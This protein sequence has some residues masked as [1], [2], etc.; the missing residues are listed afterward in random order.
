MVPRLEKLVAA[1]A[2]G[3]VQRRREEIDRFAAERLADGFT[4][5]DPL[6]S[7]SDPVLR[8]AAIEALAGNATEGVVD[9]L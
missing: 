5:L 2:S 1:I 9:W 4:I 3:N 6:L 7:S 8:I